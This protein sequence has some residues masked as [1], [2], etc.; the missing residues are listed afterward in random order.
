[1]KEITAGPKV[2]F[3]QR[4]LGTTNSMLCIVILCRCYLATGNSDS[5]EH[6]LV[7]VAK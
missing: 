3:I 4:F 2:S 7:V 6:T 1:M 5:N